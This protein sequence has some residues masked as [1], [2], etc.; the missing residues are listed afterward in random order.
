MTEVITEVINGIEVTDYREEGPE[1]GPPVS[2]ADLKVYID[3][4]V[5]ERTAIQLEINK[6][7]EILRKEKN[8]G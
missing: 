6:H 7:S 2:M 4:A 5:E 3:A 8:V 1:D